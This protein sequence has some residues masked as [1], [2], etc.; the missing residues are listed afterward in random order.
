M[1]QRLR[2]LVAPPLFEGDE[3]KT[4]TAN[5][6]YAILALI[7]GASLLYPTIL[8]ILGQSIRSPIDFILITFIVVTLALLVLVKM[9]LVQLVGVI[10]SAMIWGGFTFAMYSFGGL[11]DSAL[12]GYFVVIVLA[13]V[14][15]G[16]RMLILF[17]LASVVSVFGTYLAENSG[18][19]V[20]DIPIPS[21]VD[22]LVLVS[23][24][25]V[26]SAVLLRTAIG[27]IAGSY[28]QARQVAS[29][30]ALANQA[31]EANQ[32]ALELQTAELERRSRYQEA[33]AAVA[34]DAAALLEVQELLESTVQLIS[35]RLGF[36]HA[37]IFLIDPTGQRAI[38]QAASS[39]GGQRMVARRH[40]LAVGA[41]G[42]VGHVTGR[43]EHR[44]ALD[45]GQDQVY[46]DNPDL[47]HTRSEMA[48]PL[49]ARGEIIG[50]LDL[51]ST[52]ANAFRPEDVP[53]FQTLADQVAVAIS[54]AQ[55]YQQAQESLTAERRAYGELGGQAWQELL[56]GQQG[57]G[58]ISTRRTTSR[59]DDLWR[60]EMRAAL[61]TGEATSGQDAGSLAIPIKIRDQVIGV[62]GGRKADDAGNWEPQEIELLQAMVA[63]LNVALEDAR[64]FQESQR[65][66][67]Q[68]HVVG[69]IATELR[70]TLDVDGV[71]QTAVRQI[72]QALG[73]AEVEVRLTGEGR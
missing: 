65:R 44:I 23:V 62:V 60:S 14:V 6:L 33:T 69:E 40:R 53:V 13:G 10:V 24:L 32:Q 19:L 29:E 37:G 45:V 57:L 41:E 54:N 9:G 21:A 2:Q 30:L 49:V 28:D 42:I 3:E 46:F 73:L 35:D 11:H 39:E 61:V 48:L 59:A 63:Q 22:D 52:E 1:L 17:S 31:L 5:L 7:L 70:E 34:R 67:A 8:G 47:P 72:G 18:A 56:R 50:A 20:P 16:Q 26:F 4:R 43:G 66:A 64:L 68:E 55:L 51:Q 15:A 58:V 36:Y 12:A 27:R 25:L 71:L 38:L